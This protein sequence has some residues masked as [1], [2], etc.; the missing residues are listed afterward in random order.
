MAEPTEILT[1]ATLLQKTLKNKV[2]YKIDYF[3]KNTLPILERDT[4]S[5]Q[6]GKLKIF[7]DQW[8]H[9]IS[10][11]H[12]LNIIENGL[13]LDLMEIPPQS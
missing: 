13:K 3:I 10:D 1:E 2:N 9:I 11:K 12:L 7:L 6:G 4:L 8:G 5:F